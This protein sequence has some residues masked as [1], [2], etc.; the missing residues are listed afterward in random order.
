[1]GHPVYQ[2]LVQVLNCTNIGHHLVVVAVKV[3]I[4]KNKK[5]MGASSCLFA[6][7]AT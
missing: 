4:L 5:V 3:S 7:V 1:M 2:S 6:F